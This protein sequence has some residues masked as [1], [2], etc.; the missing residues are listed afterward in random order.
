LLVVAAVVVVD[1][2]AADNDGDT[3]VGP[4]AVD[5]TTD[6]VDDSSKYTDSS[7]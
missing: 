6:S 3:M 2:A 4:P 1:V 7:T 5:E